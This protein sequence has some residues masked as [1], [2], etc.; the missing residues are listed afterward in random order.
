MKYK[1][2]LL[3]LFIVQVAFAK[4]DSEFQWLQL[5]ADNQVVARATAISN[6][7]PDIKVDEQIFKMHVRASYEDSQ[8]HENITSC[9]YNVTGAKTV[10]IRDAK[11]VIPSKQIKK[12]VVM[13]DS[14]C[15]SSVFDSRFNNQNCADRTTWGFAK[16][17]EQVAKM[18]VDFV[19]HMGDYAYRNKY[20]TKQDK[21]KNAQ[22]QWFF[23]REEFFKPAEVLLNNT[24]MVF[25][26][27]NHESCS[28]MGKAW[29]LFLDAGSYKN[30]CFSRA[31]F[32]NINFDNIN[33]AVL[34]VSKAPVG[35]K[36]RE[37]DIEKYKKEFANVYSEVKPNTW[38]LMHHPVVALKKLN[39][40]EYFPNILESYVIKT[41]FEDSYVSK[42]PVAISG[43]F[44]AL[45]SITRDKDNFRQ[46]IVGNGGTLLHKTKKT[47]YKYKDNNSQ[48][49][50][51][52]KFG[53]LL[54]EDIGQTKWK[55]TA[56]DFDGN[57]LFSEE[58]KQ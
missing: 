48:G 33:F 11:Y 28:K 29:N 7:C 10:E 25:I 38:L 20:K 54:F 46:F 57:V 18:N 44:H 13:G 23:F 36:Y 16:V 49:Q 56:Y 52:V 37:K 6:Q 8:L 40:Q 31:P 30:E 55:V 19:V 12:F 15:E 2:K 4:E 5:V 53:F 39:E 17:A 35:Q 58:I 51:A 22:M 26:R 42:I 41:A 45:A 27:G 50:V 24:P 9:E 14:G 47:Y 34:D 32:Y 3:L 43:H 21:E 1:I